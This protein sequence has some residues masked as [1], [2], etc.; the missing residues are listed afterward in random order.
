MKARPGCIALMQR[1]IEQAP[2]I[3]F[4]DIGE[5]DCQT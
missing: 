5:C 3:C 2:E 4:E 1:F